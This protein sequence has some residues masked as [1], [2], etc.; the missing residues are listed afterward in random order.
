MWLK[1]ISLWCLE[2]YKAI[3][4]KLQCVKLQ[5]S[6]APLYPLP[7]L[8]CMESN[9]SC[10]RPGFETIFI[11]VYFTVSVRICPLIGWNVRGDYSTADSRTSFLTAADLAENL[12]WIFQTKKWFFSW[13]NVQKLG[14][15]F[16]NNQRSIQ[17]CFYCKFHVKR[18]S[19]TGIWLVKRRKIIFPFLFKDACGV[20]KD[21]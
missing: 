3:L 7:C 16:S 17:D 14:S 1:S 5:S 9:V 13:C 11:H 8:W 19:W 21:S 18:A 15:R 6:F 4:R 20:D 2:L 12:L 10:E